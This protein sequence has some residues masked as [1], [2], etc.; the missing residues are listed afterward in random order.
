MNS[1]TN[2][3]STMVF[4]HNLRQKT[5]MARMKCLLVWLRRCRHSRGF[6]V[7]S[8][9]AYRLVRYVINEHYPYY[10]YDDLAE[11][12][13]KYAVRWRKLAKLYFRLANYLQ[14]E[15][16]LTYTSYAKMYEKYI[17]R[18]C[19]HCAVRPLRHVTDIPD[20]MRV[21]TVALKGDFKPICER[22]VASAHSDSLLILEGIH[23]DKR[24]LAYWREL[25]MDVRVG[26]TFDLYDCGL[27]FFDKKHHK[28]NY[29]VNF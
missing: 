4:F 24:T 8:P 10:A 29:I 14:A 15:E 17:A 6:G 25:M 19:N 7:Q 23:D 22:L 13:R 9:W 28:R 27:I 11:S 26:V 20:G 3:K 12:S 16:W 2:C 18:G 5:L 1:T 21:A